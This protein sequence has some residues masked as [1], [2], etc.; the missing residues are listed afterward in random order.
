M[1]DYKTFSAGDRTYQR[2]QQAWQILTAWVALEC[3][4]DAGDYGPGII[5][6]G[7]LG[8]YMGFDE[9]LAGRNAIRPVRHIY[10]F[11]AANDLPLLSAMVV[12]KDTGE[13]AWDYGD[14]ADGF[15]A[16]QEKVRA[17]GREWFDIRTPTGALFKQY[18]LIDTDV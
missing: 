6:Y 9:Q 5:T 12:R 18:P 8:R 11:C 4:D 16:A 14:H 15:E 1:P 10:R 17:Y 3:V 7:T 2:A 13:P